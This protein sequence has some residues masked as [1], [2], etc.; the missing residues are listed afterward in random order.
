MYRL[1]GFQ[2]G[3]GSRGQGQFVV[4]VVFWP[5]RMAFVSEGV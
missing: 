4:Y 5:E 1:V 3:K 2:M